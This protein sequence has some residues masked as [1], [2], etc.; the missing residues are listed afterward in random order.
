MLPAFLA[1]CPP[2]LAPPP[3]PLDQFPHSFSRRFPYPRSHLTLSPCLFGSSSL[4]SLALPAPPPQWLNLRAGI[5]CRAGRE[6]TRVAR[7]GRA[8]G[9]PAWRRQ[10]GAESRA[11]AKEAASRVKQRAE[12]SHLLAERQPSHARGQQ[13]RA[14]LPPQL[15][16]KK[17]GRSRRSGLAPSAAQRRGALR[18]RDAGRVARGGWLGWMKRVPPPQCHL[19]EG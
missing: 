10:R 11:V 3:F 12:P 2:G 1:S 4:P 14:R 7:G 8:A 5:G 9:A 16:G 13:R 19:R 15:P 18:G 6:E 17:R